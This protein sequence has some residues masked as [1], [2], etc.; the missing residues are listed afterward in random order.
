MTAL[1]SRTQAMASSE[2]RPSVCKGVAAVNDVIVVCLA[3]MRAT[4]FSASTTT[5]EGSS[6]VEV[7]PRNRPKTGSLDAASDTAF[8]SK[9]ARQMFPDLLRAPSSAARRVLL[10][11]SFVGRVRRAFTMVLR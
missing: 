4:A 7:T 9:R 2:S 3:T 5:V 10:G 8:G 6:F 11:Q 1:S